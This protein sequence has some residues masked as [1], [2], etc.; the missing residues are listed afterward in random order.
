[1]MPSFYCVLMNGLVQ[2]AA[3]LIE[4]MQK[5]VEGMDF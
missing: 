4:W 5:V 2:T 3:A 1:M